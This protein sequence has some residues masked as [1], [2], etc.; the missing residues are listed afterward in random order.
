[1]PITHLRP[2]R[3]VQAPIS[4][5]LFIHALSLHRARDRTLRQSRFVRSFMFK[6]EGSLHSKRQITAH[7]RALRTHKLAVL[8]APA[9]APRTT[10]ISA[11]RLGRDMPSLHTFSASSE[12]SL[13]LSI[14]T[15]L[16][17]SKFSTPFTPANQVLHP[18]FQ[19]PE[20]HKGTPSKRH[21]NWQWSPVLVP[22]HTSPGFDENTSPAHTP[23]T[24]DSPICNLT[25]RLSLLSPPVGIH[26]PRR[27]SYSQAC[28]SPYTP[29]SSF[30]QA[31]AS[32]VLIR[33]TLWTPSPPVAS[34]R[35]QL[36]DFQFSPFQL[37]L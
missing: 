32:P 31:L 9:A 22:R 5:P 23:A 18:P 14:K 13:V 3:S 7:I 29:D 2:V 21:R 30:G 35:Y 17:A 10:S 4:D 1:M 24:P 28:A 36:D 26:V 8:S 37:A 11:R 34:P 20:P 33:S 15:P 12:S 27:L 19:P 16:P 6:K 25:R